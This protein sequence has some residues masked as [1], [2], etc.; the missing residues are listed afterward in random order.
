[1]DNEIRECVEE[2]VAEIFWL[3]HE[4]DVMDISEADLM[5]IIEKHIDDMGTL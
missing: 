5:D 1:M 3:Y 2:A 4:K